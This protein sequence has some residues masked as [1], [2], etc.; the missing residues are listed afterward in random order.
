MTNP[1][2]S[3]KYNL[4]YGKV[5]GIVKNIDNAKQLANILYQIGTTIGLSNDELMKYVSVNGLKFNNQVYAQLNLSRT[6]SSQIGFIDE[7][8]IP[9]RISQQ[10]V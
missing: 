7:N 9:P 5:L 2:D 8:N 6:N 3:D 4:L 10:V 1:V